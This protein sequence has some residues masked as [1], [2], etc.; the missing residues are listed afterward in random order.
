MGI[1]NGDEKKTNLP[2]KLMNYVLHWRHYQLKSE[3]Y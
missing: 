3:L 2:L 1:F